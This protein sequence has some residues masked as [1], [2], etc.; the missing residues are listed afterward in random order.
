[1]LCQ[2]CHEQEATVHVTFVVGVS[3]DVTKRDFCGS[4][5]PTVEAEHVQAYNQQP[6][7]PLPDDVENITAQEFFAARERASRNGVDIPAFKHIREHIS[8]SLLT[9]QRLAFE[10]MELAWQ[11]MER[12]EDPGMHMTFAGSCWTSIESQRRKEYV[13]WLEKIIIRCFEL[14][15]QQCP[16]FMVDGPFAHTLSLS[17]CALGCVERNRFTELL[18]EIRKRVG[19]QNS[20]ARWQVLADAEQTV[21]RFAKRKQR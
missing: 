20:D 21:L 2:K 16:P 7:N 14:C 4:C 19:D 1:M 9:R 17:L 11:S 15:G 12:G 5:Y 8:K 10:M 3:A 6:N 18:E 13:T